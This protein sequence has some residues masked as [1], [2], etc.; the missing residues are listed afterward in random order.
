MIS[1]QREAWANRKSRKCDLVTK[2]TLHAKKTKTNQSKKKRKSNSGETGGKNK[3]L[4]D[5]AEGASHRGP[6]GPRLIAN[7]NG[8]EQIRARCPKKE[9]ANFFEEAARDQ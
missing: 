1:R 8:G 9:R 3:G 5:C 6:P 4:K 2:Q 7:L